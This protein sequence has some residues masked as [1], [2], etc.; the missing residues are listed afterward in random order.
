MGLPQNS[1]QCYFSPCGPCSQVYLITFLPVLMSLYNLIPVDLG[2]GLCVHACLYVRACMCVHTYVYMCMFVHLCI[3][4]TC[5]VCMHACVYAC[6][7]VYVYVYVQ[8]C[9]CSLMCS[10]L[11]A[12]SDENILSPPCL[13]SVFCLETSL[14]PFL[15]ESFWVDTWSKF[16]G[17]TW[18]SGIAT[19][20]IP[21]QQCQE[22]VSAM[23]T[24][25][26]PD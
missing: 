12:T 4:W 9:V 22:L 5:I 8:V 11:S 10:I 19:D 2:E 25:P 17:C 6:A 16:Q 18:D 23:N 1:Q 24:G 7:C 26:T 15:L 3:V 14:L 13:S 20:S 21:Y